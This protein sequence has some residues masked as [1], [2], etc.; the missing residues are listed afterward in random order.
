MTPA[1]VIRKAKA[2]DFD[3]I[4]YL[5]T[6]L[7]THLRSVHSS[8]YQESAA[9]KKRFAKKLAGMLQDPNARVLCAVAGKQVVGFA[10]GRIGQSPLFVLHN[11][12][13]EIDEV[14]VDHSFRKQGI[15]RKLI[16]ELIAWFKTKKVKRMELTVDAYNAVAIKA[17]KALGFNTHLLIMS[18]KL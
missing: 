2:S 6:V 5:H 17:W 18:R 15:T 14:V 3:A 9:E 1:I 10:N 13:G 8:R 16:S 12:F 4:C 7:L 11:R